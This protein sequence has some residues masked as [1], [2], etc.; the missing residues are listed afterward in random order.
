MP[1]AQSS[2]RRAPAP[3]VR[4]PPPL[5]PVLAQSSNTSLDSAL[6]GGG[7]VDTMRLINL[8]SMLA[9]AFCQ[10]RTFAYKFKCSKARTKMIDTNL[11]SL[12]TSEHA[13]IVSIVLKF[14]EYRGKLDPFH[15]IFKYPK[16]RA[17]PAGLQ[18]NHFVKIYESFIPEL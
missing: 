6:D 11:D 1:K 15:E 2:R 16:R 17:L 12:A 8:R 13:E 3:Y 18:L 4:P 9:Y 5:E 10:K 7:T 14:I